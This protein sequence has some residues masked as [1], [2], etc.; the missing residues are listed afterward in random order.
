M[1]LLT[2]ENSTGPLSRSF[3][4][5]GVPGNYDVIYE[6]IRIIR[7]S[8]YYDIQIERIAK[9]Q[10]QNHGLNSYSS[11]R[12]QL[13]VIYRFVKANVAYIQDKA[14]LVESIKSA[15]V[16]LADGYGDCDDLTN[17]IATLVG[18]LGFEDVRLAMARYFETD[19][20]F[21]HV[22]PVVYAEGER[23]ALDATLPNGKIGDEVNA[24]EVKEIPVF[25]DVPGLDGISGLFNNARH[26]SKQ[27]AKATV[28]T[29]PAIATYLPLGFVASQALATGA[30]LL[31]KT[32]INTELSLNATAS[33]INKELDKTIVALVRSQIA[34]DLAKS[35]ALQVSSQLSAVKVGREDQ[36]LYNTVKQSISTRL[37]FI[38]N[39]EA[40]AAE[41]DITVVFLNPSLILAAGIAGAGF[42]AY[43]LIQL[44]RKNKR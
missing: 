24:L 41:H 4:R 15:R 8:V 13:G 36:E 42:G 22:Y 28:E 25:T 2:Q 37:Q 16:T 23:F 26:Y 33:K 44:I 31:N 9:D 35:Y 11:A 18:C 20:A 5:D 1:E 29:L 40:F 39:F 32:G 14:G 27:V 19:T 21:V 10:L 3:I 17:T 6:M 43:A 38:N 7:N 12:A 30:Q 34:L